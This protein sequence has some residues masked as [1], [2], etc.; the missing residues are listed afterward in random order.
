[1]KIR[2]TLIVVATWSGR[3][4]AFGLFLFWGAFFLEHLSE[5]F[6]HPGI[7]FPSAKIW[8]LQLVHLLLLIGLLVL[9]R[10]EWQGSALTILAALVF[11]GSVAGRNFPVFFAVTVLPVFLL[12][13]AR[14]IKSSTIQ[15]AT[16]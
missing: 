11:F 13:T 8:F 16:Q 15:Q 12:L 1:M 2:K 5:W 7:G 3:L 4:L 14:L 9:L 10:W 6:T